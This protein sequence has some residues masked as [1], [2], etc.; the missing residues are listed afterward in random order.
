MNGV[1]DMGGMHGMGPV[2]IEKNEPVY[3][4]KWEARVHALNI[5]CGYHRK[6]N[7]DV[8][9]HSRERIPPAEYLAATYYEK[10]LRGLEMLLVE[11][12]LVTAKELETGRAE[13]K[14]AGT[15]VL[16]APEVASF[17]RVRRLARMDADV[18]PKFRPGDRVLTRND[19]PTGHTRLSTR[20]PGT[21]GVIN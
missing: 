2:E 7:I 9:R 14:A 18:R 12:G 16:Q 19:H 17:L 5:A 6:W 15:S 3:H 11:N 20:S 21:R 8:A 4:S 10:W 13:S 1:H